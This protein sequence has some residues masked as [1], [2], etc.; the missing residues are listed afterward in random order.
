MAAA[1]DESQ[2]DADDESQGEDGRHHP[3]IQRVG[4]AS[5]P[6]GLAGRR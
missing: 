1:D 4:G 2:D 5:G 3:D 6:G